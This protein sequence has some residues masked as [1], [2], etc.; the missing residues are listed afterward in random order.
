MKKYCK[1]YHIGDLRRFDGWREQRE[2]QEPELSDEAIVYV[3][4][5]LSVV[6]SPITP[7]KSI[8]FANITPAWQTFC[9]EELH[10]A[11]PADLP[12]AYRQ[13]EKTS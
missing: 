2:D 7:D 13:A 1:A 9:Q 3:C 5:D 11:L 10:F 12:Q 8:V 6:R 4:D